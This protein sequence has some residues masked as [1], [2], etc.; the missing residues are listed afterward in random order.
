MSCTCDAHFYASL[1][2]WEMSL[3]YIDV[4]IESFIEIGRLINRLN[5]YWTTESKRTESESETKKHIVAI[6]ITI[7]Y[8]CK[9][10]IVH[11]RHWQNGQQNKQAV[12]ENVEHEKRGSFSRL[13]LVAFVRDSVA[14]A[15]P[16]TTP[17]IEKIWQKK[18]SMYK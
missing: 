8:Y 15:A 2:D 12:N 16:A 1:V 3:M 7:I 9:A 18:N 6:V 5:Y 4:W 17:T 13:F 11:H 10:N 14:W